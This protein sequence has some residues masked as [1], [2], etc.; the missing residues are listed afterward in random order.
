MLQTFGV[1]HPRYNGLISKLTY[2]V[3]VVFLVIF[4]GIPLYFVTGIGA[5]Y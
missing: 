2:I 5:N 3:P 1:N 4:S